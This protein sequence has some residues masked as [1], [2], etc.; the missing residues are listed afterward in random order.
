MK[1]GEF[2]NK[3][4]DGIETLDVYDQ[5]GYDVTEDFVIPD[6]SEV[7]HAYREN[8]RFAIQIE[9]RTWIPTMCVGANKA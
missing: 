9:L 7:T 6:N 8:G 2:I 3:Y 1:Y 5:Y 4:A